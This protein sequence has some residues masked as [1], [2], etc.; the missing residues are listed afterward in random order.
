MIKFI[1]EDIIYK[2][3]LFRTLVFDESS[4]NKNNIIALRDKYN[5]RRIQISIY[6]PKANGMVER[7]YNP[8]IRVFLILTNSG[9]KS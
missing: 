8:I 7:E 4:E 9:K 6:N 2:H 1:W 3:R 5:F